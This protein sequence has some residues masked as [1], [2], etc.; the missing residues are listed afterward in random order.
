VY[1]QNQIPV[2][3]DG[4]VLNI[5]GNIKLKPINNIK[6]YKSVAFNELSEIKKGNF[7]FGL[8]FRDNLRYPFYLLINDSI[9]TDKFYLN[10]KNNS[11]IIDSLINHPKPRLLLKSEQIDKDRFQFKNQMNDAEKWYM[12]KYDSIKCTINGTPTKEDL[13]YFSYLR[14]TDL[15]NLNKN[16]EKFIIEN[17][18]SEFALWTLVSLFNGNGYNKIYEDSYFKFNSKIKKS[19]VGEELMKSFRNSK[20]LNVGK[21]FPLIKLKSTSLQDV[22]MNLHENPNRN[23]F[24]LVDF[25][26]TN[27]QA[28]LLGFNDLKGI[29]SQ[30]KIKNFEIVSV[31]TD[32]SQKLNDWIKII[33]TKQLTWINYIDI[34]AEY[35]HLFNINSFPTNFLIDSNG[36]IIVK[37]ISPKELEIFLKENLE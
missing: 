35:A 9:F 26:F 37:N 25:W 14:K 20:E 6:F 36:K 19:S 7:K 33:E 21:V 2:T 5:N 18:N 23:K 31:S 30:Y 12:D 32:K 24:T 28:C 29:Y 27:C 34:N 11:I 10:N 13:N 1:S 15:E 4:N 17:P 16:L 22:D 8:T 3:I